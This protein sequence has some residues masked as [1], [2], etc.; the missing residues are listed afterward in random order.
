MKTATQILAGLGIAQSRDR[1]ASQYCAR[2]PRCS[3]GRSTKAHRNQKCLAVNIDRRGVRWRCHHCEWEGGQFFDEESRDANALPPSIAPAPDNRRRA[4]EIW[5][6][7]S[8]FLGS[9]GHS[10]LKSRA[11]T[12]LPPGIEQALRFH[13]Q[14]PFN[15]ARR[16]CIVALFRDVLTNEP[17]A[18][19]RISIDGGGKWSLGP[20]SGCA[21]KLSR[22]EDVTQGLTIGEGVETTLAA[23][24]Y[25]FRP[26]WAC[27]V[28]SNL[29][30]F[31]M[32]AGI[33]EL[34]IIVDNDKPDERGHRKGIEAALECS[35]RWTATGRTVFRVVPNETGADF[36]DV[37]K[38]WAS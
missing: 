19:H 1:N 35:A 9:P 29:A 14:C 18:V 27:V 38:D 3:D 26:A 31:P 13:P 32:L 16:P 24:Q 22:D 30:A 8:P 21:V 34:T 20:Q 6:A 7:S 28:A 4:L 33:D 15:G 2:C 11:L 10:Y 36:N 23:W 12:E 25:G 37:I 17:K 5:K